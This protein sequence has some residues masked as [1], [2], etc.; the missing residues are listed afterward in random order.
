MKRLATLSIHENAFDERMFTGLVT[1]L[2]NTSQFRKDSCEDIIIRMME[3]GALGSVTVT[4]MIVKMAPQENPW[5]NNR[6]CSSKVYQGAHLESHPKIFNRQTAKV[7]TTP[8]KQ[9]RWDH[10]TKYLVD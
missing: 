10:P 7:S 3:R 2:H 9:R 8:C 4:T 1:A 6:N 5:E